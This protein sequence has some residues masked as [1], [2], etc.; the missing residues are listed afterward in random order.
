M[1]IDF[2]TEEIFSLAD[3]AKSLPRRRGGKKVHLSCAY[4][5]TKTGC[6]GVI[7][8][9]IQIGGT[10]CTSKEALARFFQRLTFGKGSAPEAPRS[11]AGRRRAAERAERELAREGV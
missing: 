4:R 6:R 1:A 7:L 8:E 2:H 10:R 5:W 11:P 3:A 9:S